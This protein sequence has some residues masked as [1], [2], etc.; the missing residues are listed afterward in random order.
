[1]P[2]LVG[3]NSACG[4]QCF[5]YADELTMV[6]NFDMEAVLVAIPASN[7]KI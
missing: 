4:S 7:A 1:M 2:A 3:Y 6:E 5:S